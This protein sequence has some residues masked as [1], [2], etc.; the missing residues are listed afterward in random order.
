MTKKTDQE[1][2][3]LLMDTRALLR[4]ERFAAAGSR[5]KDSNAPKNLR[6][7]VARILT[8]KSARVLRSSNT[9]E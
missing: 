2:M 7:V 9:A 5:A 4:T 6:A 1:L 3:T 8:E